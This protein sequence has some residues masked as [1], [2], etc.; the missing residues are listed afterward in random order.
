[1]IRV[2]RGDAILLVGG[3][4]PARR[5]LAALLQGAGYACSVA[6]A[7]LEASAMLARERFS[8]V[9]CR[10]GA[11][12]AEDLDRYEDALAQDRDVA[13]ILLARRDE[14]DTADR[15]NAFGY[16]VEPVADGELLVY[17]A[18]A[19]RRRDVE[20]ENR[21]HRER[22]EEM[23]AQRTLALVDA[24]RRLERSTDELRQLDADAQPRAGIR[25]L[26]VEDHEGVRKG[27]ELL[28]RD[29]GFDVV[30]TAGEAAQA[31][32]LIARRRPQV[33]VIDI[34]LPG[35][36]GID[37]TRRLLAQAGAPR[38][39]LYT[40]SEDEGTLSA[41]I[42]VGAAGLA[43]KA[44]PPGE[45]AQAIR[46]VARGLDYFDPRLDSLLARSKSGAVL[47]PRERQVLDMLASGLNG[48]QIAAELVLSP[49]TVRTH[50]TN[51]MNK[52]AVRTR[53]HAVTEA[54]RR[55]EISL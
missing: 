4:E 21:A 27:I 5:R 25:V 20:L 22:M 28:L 37:L 29:E 39:L 1:M 15:L 50:L 31:E 30:G 9:V 47:T 8:L 23:V 51:A 40:G 2:P 52:L 26:I 7:P 34:N 18:C 12:S 49:E 42:E 55:R 38:V 24:V 36:G 17:V 11:P 35:E 19:L 13:T 32:T 44:A 33:A 43:S 6:P 14:I 10:L 41:A 48:E 46:D 53:V 16:L 54:L 45:L 3:D